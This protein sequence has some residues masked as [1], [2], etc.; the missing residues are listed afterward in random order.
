MF[1][2][3]ALDVAAPG[4]LFAFGVLPILAGIVVVALAVYF[5]VRAIKKGKSNKQ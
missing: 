2:L 1:L 3:I 4:L 5:I